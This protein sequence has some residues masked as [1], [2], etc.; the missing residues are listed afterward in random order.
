MELDLTEWEGVLVKNLQL[1]KASRSLLKRMG[2]EA[3]TL[4]VMDRELRGKILAIREEREK[5]ERDAD[6][7]L[8]EDTRD[9]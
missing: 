1:V 2:L 3:D 4:K 5:V 9:G 7:P 6:R 8:I